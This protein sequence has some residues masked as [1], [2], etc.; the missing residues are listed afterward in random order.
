MNSTA[1]DASLE[2]ERE[3][4]RHSFL[5]DL[6]VRLIKEKPL[7]T[8][9]GVIV[10]VMFLVGIFA[11][12]LAPYGMNEIHLVERL[13]PPSAKYIFGTDDLGRDVFSR[14]IGGA[15]IS[16]IVGVAGSCLTA[17][18]ALI[19][20][21][22]CAFIGGKFDITIQRIVDA[23]MAFPMIF[24]GLT[25]IA[26]LGPGLVQVILVLGMFDGIR[27]SRVVRA[28]AM[29]I[30]ENVYVQAALTV[31]CSDFRILARHI[32]PNIMAPVI[33]VVTVC[34][35]HMIMAEATLSFLGLGIPPP[36]PSWGGM[37]SAEG[38]QFMAMAP[39][40]AIWPG[41]ALSAAVFGINMLGDG[42]RDL[43]D[44]R[45]RGSLGRYGGVKVKKMVR[46]SNQ[47]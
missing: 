47:A 35:G 14:V 45:L 21:I 11:D 43:L 19:I 41:F 25:A 2:T 7:G 5:I 22:S 3:Q 37:L 13:S 4:K 15:R 44:P 18:I 33:I 32:L 31:G 20:G 12:Q 38:R 9:G 46:K 10:L 27:N 1:R 6:I 36:L 42:M 8:I 30:K 39:W 16:M 34:M 17:V 24:V 26:L 40:M 29:A 23:W 28:A